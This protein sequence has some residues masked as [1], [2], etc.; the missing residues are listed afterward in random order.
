[1]SAGCR[2]GFGEC[3]S[4]EEADA[5]ADE[6]AEGAEEKSSDEEA[7]DDDAGFHGIAGVVGGGGCEPEVDFADDETADAE[8]FGEIAHLGWD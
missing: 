2:G 3:G 6:C 1:M 5:H 8:G 7:L 4:D